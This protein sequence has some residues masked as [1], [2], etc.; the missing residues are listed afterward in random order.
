MEI[1]ASECYAFFKR[2]VAVIPKLSVKY[3]L[4]KKTPL[5]QHSCCIKFENYYIQK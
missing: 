5:F 4:Q 2:H 1:K 3:F